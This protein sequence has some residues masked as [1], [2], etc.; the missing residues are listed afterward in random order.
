MAA[1]LAQVRGR[2]AR[3]RFAAGCARAVAFPPGG[4][5]EAVGITGAV[6]VAATA[7][8]VLVTGAALPAM[9]VFA[10]A[11]VGLLGGLAT[12]TVARSRRVRR[13]G[14]ARRSPG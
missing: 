9:R 3:W 14:P 1:E 4:S 11:F 2:A 13:A 8:T 10:L 7:A 5:R 12:L 6:A